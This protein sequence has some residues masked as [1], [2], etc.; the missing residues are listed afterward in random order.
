[1]LD[2]AFSYVG[3]PVTILERFRLD[4]QVSVVT[5]AGRG[6]GKAIALC[7]A[8]A[9]AKVVCAARTQAAV[10][11]VVSQ[12]QEMGGAALAVSCD[13]SSSDAREALLEQAF[14]KFGRLD[15]LVNNAGGS[16]P[17]DPLKTTPE[18][19]GESLAW[20]VVPAFDLTR[21][22]VPLM[23]QSG[24]GSVL[25]ISS[26]AAHYRLPNFSV[27]GSAKAALSHLTRLLAQDF[28]PDIRVNA[29]EPGPIRTTALEKVLT[30]EREQAMV[31][32]TPLGRLGVPE[33]VAASALFLASPAASWITGKIVELDGGVESPPTW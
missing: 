3:S 8:Q 25:N 5:G 23:R 24:G 27:Y 12:I 22:A 11:S 6:I 18:Q 30:P 15:A 1:M 10:E 16:P 31:K 29:I 20:N 17:N 13:V 28:A 4:D 19:F 21:L 2:F 32:S 9:G 14:K 33:D 26:A 7:F